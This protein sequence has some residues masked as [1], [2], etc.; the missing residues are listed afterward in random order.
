MPEENTVCRLSVGD[1]VE[2][3]KAHGKFDVMM[4]YVKAAVGIYP[5]IP[6]SAKFALQAF[7]RLYAYASMG[8]FWNLSSCFLS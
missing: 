4:Q 1:E 5:S 8:V 3:R 7:K 2:G 6:Y